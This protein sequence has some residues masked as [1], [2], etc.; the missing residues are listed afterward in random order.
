MLTA[1][2][3]ALETAPW[4]IFFPGLAISLAV[5]ALNLL[6]D[7]IRDLDRPRLRG[8][9]RVAGSPRSDSNDDTIM[10]LT[11]IVSLVRRGSSCSSAR[12][13]SAQDKPR[14]A[15]SSTGSTTATP[16]GSTCTRS[17]RWS[18]SRPP[19]AST[20]GCSTTIRTIPP[21][22]RRDLAER[23]TVSPDGKT[24]TFHLRKGVKW[25]DGQPFTSADVKATFDRVLNPDF[26]SPKCGATLKPIVASVEAVD[27]T[28]SSSGSSS[29]AGAV[30]RRRW[31]RRGAASPPSTCW[32]STATST[33]PRPRSAP[34]RSS[35][36]STS[37]AA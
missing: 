4:M 37:A 11:R 1:G 34:G 5:F 28:R 29:R 12:P 9:P 14:Q 23:W 33:R 26:K 21:R 30:P 20:A 10:R 24:Y 17:R 6:G 3:Q 25:H 18:S 32:R 13:R 22:S 8:R 35:S 16:A 15:A 19:R 27:A 31:R 2:T 36:R 7:A